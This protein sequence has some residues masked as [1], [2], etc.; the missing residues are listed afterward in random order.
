MKYVST[1]DLAIASITFTSG[2]YGFAFRM[3]STPEVFLDEGDVD[4]FAVRAEVV[5]NTTGSPDPEHP[6]GLDAGRDLP[7]FRAG[8][9]GGGSYIGYAFNVGYTRATLQAALAINKRQ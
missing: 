2:T 6:L 5:R 3:K 4:M 1:S 9:P 7:G 8:Y